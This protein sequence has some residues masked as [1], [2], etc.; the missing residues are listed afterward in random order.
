MEEL[1]FLLDG[2]SFRYFGG[3]LL[4]WRLFFFYGGKWNKMLLGVPILFIMVSYHINALH[5]TR[6]EK[7]VKMLKIMCI[8]QLSLSLFSILYE[9]K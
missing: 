6:R 8:T 7:S 9:E 2:R 4:S 5:I 1:V 3:L